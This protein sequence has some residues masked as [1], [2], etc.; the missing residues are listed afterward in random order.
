MTYV[1]TEAGSAVR[2]LAGP[3]RQS[4]GQT[5]EVASDDAYIA[6][7]PVTAI[8]RANRA[9][10]VVN[11]ATAI[12]AEDAALERADVLVHFKRVREMAALAA[13]LEQRKRVIDRTDPLARIKRHQLAVASAKA[14]EAAERV[15]AQVIES[16]ARFADIDP[17]AVYT[18]PGEDA[19]EATIAEAV[20]VKARTEEFC[21]ADSSKRA[22]IGRYNKGCKCQSCKRAV[23]TY[24]AA[25]R[26]NKEAK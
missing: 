13:K 17:D 4:Q 21:D 25:K 3:V 10:R 22:S 5:S 12:V 26:A 1:S 19:P 16:D 2:D 20:A 18:E 7:K 8:E 11:V 23:A 24:R 14:C 9:V 15:A 6:D